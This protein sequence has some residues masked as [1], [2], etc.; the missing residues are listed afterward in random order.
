MCSFVH[1]RSITNAKDQ[2]E[3]KVTIISITKGNNDNFN[4]NSNFN[5]NFIFIIISL[6]LIHCWIKG[7]NLHY[8]LCRYIKVRKD[9]AWSQPEHFLNISDGH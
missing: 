6:N 7:F 4:F 3:N 5:N 2:I 1:N 8:F 9:M